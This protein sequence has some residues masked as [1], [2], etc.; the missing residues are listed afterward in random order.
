MAK[1]FISKPLNL[2]DKVFLLVATRKTLAV[3]EMYY[4]YTRSLN[5]ISPIS[6]S[7]PTETKVLDYTQKS[8]ENISLEQA[9]ELINTLSDNIKN[10]VPYADSINGYDIPKK[11]LNN[12]RLSIQSMERHL[13]NFRDKE[14][15]ADKKLEAVKEYKP[16]IPMYLTEPIEAQGIKFHLLYNIASQVIRLIAITDKGLEC[17]DINESITNL[18]DSIDKESNN[19]GLQLLESK[20]QLILTKNE[21]EEWIPSKAITND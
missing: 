4:D 11:Q 1:Y 10:N 3:L 20:V 13:N 2:S 17:T 7:D 15:K 5:E 12:I 21:L 16:T 8:I 19:T 18:Y 9:W 14:I 6:Y